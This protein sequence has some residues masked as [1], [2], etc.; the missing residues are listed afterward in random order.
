MAE[1]TAADY[2]LCYLRDDSTVVVEQT[3]LFGKLIEFAA[4]LDQLRRRIKLSHSPLVQND[5]PVRVNDGVD[6]VRN[7]NN[8]SIR[9][10]AAAQGPLQQCIRF[11]V[12]CGLEPLL[13]ETDRQELGQNSLTVASSKTRMLL[14]VKRARARDTSWRWP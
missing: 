13:A 2:F 6:A 8:G 1:V 11:H 4:T 10:D 14:G 12:H 3:G 9:E 7:G 5:D